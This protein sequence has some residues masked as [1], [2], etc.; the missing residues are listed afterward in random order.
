VAAKKNLNYFALIHAL[1]ADP[2]R[3]LKRLIPDNSLLWT[4]IESADPRIIEPLIGF[5]PDIIPEID[6]KWLGTWLKLKLQETEIK[7]THLANEAKIKQYII[8]R[9]L[10]GKQDLDKKDRL[11]VLDSLNRLTSRR[12]SKK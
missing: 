2:E 11:A 7:P 10:N 6:S 8:S 9:F 12:A 1:K 5:R 3:M 4:M